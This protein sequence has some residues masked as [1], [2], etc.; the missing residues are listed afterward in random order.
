[1]DEIRRGLERAWTANR[2]PLAG[3][4]ILHDRQLTPAE[5]LRDEFF[6]DANVRRLYA[7][8][9]PDGDAL[10]EIVLTQLALEGDELSAE[11]RSRLTDREA[12]LLERH[13]SEWTGARATCARFTNR[14][15]GEC[16]VRF[17]PVLGDDDHWELRGGRALQLPRRVLA[18]DLLERGAA[19][20]GPGPVPPVC[21][22]GLYEVAAVQVRV[23]P[24]L[25]PER[26]ER[27]MREV[28]PIT[29][30]RLRHLRQNYGPAELSES[31]ARSEV[32]ERL[33][34]L[35]LWSY[36]LGNAHTRLVLESPFLKNLRHLELTSMKQTAEAFEPL[37][38]DERFGK[39]ERL[40]F[41][42]LDDQDG[43]SELGPEFASL[44]GRAKHLNRLE[45]L[46]V[47]FASLEV[48]GVIEL[49]RSPA[50]SGLRHLDVSENELGEEGIADL[51]G[52]PGLARLRSL[53]LSC[54][55]PARALSALLDGTSLHGVE[56]LGIASGALDDKAG[57]V[58]LLPANID[59]PRL[60]SLD[61]SFWDLRGEVASRLAAAARLPA[62]RS[63]SLAYAKLD[64]NSFATLVRSPMFQAVE[65]V[66]IFSTNVGDRG[67]RALAPSPWGPRLRRLKLGWVRDV[68][69][70]ADG[71]AALA[72][73]HAST[74]NV[75]DFDETHDDVLDDIARRLVAIPEL[76]R[77]TRIV[78]S[79]SSA[80]EILRSR[81][82]PRVVAPHLD[83]GD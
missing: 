13:G 28:R 22:E 80:L 64:D 63:L 46:H 26:R 9:L 12:E 29:E 57:H 65:E 61:L 30:M 78:V 70:S 52:E 23:D 42:R 76:N 1:L 43:N 47:P 51:A 33:H 48:R 41:K 71:I 72:K 11:E 75:I 4:R 83:A 3:A 68:P 50:L 54:A 5:V 27:L 74:L 60:R 17:G 36:N 6:E 53:N 45:S 31:L 32:L 44:L 79:P 73:S 20:L 39:L 15:T 58:P 14:E 8:A 16:H 19:A 59:R 66:D 37:A 82:G 24:S 2:D 67:L 62:L 69:I 81:W 55:A 40:R 35:D 56:R 7:T 77:I 10:R 49:L 21:I 25:S 34:D 18:R 38:C